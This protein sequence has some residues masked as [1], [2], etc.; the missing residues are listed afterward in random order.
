MRGGWGCPRL[1]A[2]RGVA[3]Q[4]EQTGGI[5]GKHTPRAPLVSRTAPIEPSTIEPRQPPRHQSRHGYLHQTV[6]FAREGWWLG[7]WGGR[8]WFCCIY[9]SLP[10]L[11][12]AFA[13]RV[14]GLLPPPK[15][16]R[17]CVVPPACLGEPLAFATAAA[18]T[19]PRRRTRDR[20]PPAGA[21]RATL[22]AHLST[23]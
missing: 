4:V 19:T 14:H 9:R 2:G 6:S 11:L 22:S 17:W 3:G 1:T 20:P 13:P 18:I 10:R 23:C 5:D 21:R 8:E 15:T 16:A 12:P 7:W